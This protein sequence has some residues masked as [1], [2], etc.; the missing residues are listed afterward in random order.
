MSSFGSKAYFREDHVSGGRPHL[1]EI[2][3]M[4][5]AAFFCRANG[6]TNMVTNRL[7]QLSEFQSDLFRSIE[8][9]VIF[10]LQEHQE[11]FTG[12]LHK[13][14]RLGDTVAQDLL[15]G[16]RDINLSVSCV[17]A[18]EDVIG[19]RTEQ[20][21]GVLADPLFEGRKKI[22]ERSLLSE[23]TARERELLEYLR[24]PKNTI[25]GFSQRIGVR[26]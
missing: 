18:S 3:F 22:E 13:A 25:S 17:T 8:P 4:P 1:N 14:T 15:C 16:D 26:A 9:A 6:A 21:L 12:L 24:D 23:L 7:R 10:Q 20:F 19:R 5:M 11:V 2:S